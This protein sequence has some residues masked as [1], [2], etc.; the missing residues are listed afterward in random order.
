MLF[1]F[2][3]FAKKEKP[4][5]IVKKADPVLGHHIYKNSCTSESDYTI[6]IKNTLMQMKFINLSNSS[7]QQFHCSKKNRENP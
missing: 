4:D 3:H 6:F 5:V 7:I 1:D 2:M